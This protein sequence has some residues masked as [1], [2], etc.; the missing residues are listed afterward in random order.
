VV[1]VGG[2]RCDLAT[3]I[4]APD[5]RHAGD[6]DQQVS[7]IPFERNLEVRELDR[8]TR[9][10]RGNHDFSEIG[11]QVGRQHHHERHAFPHG[12]DRVLV[13]IELPHSPFPKMI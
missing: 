11:E 3:K 13:Q 4:R 6:T 8:P 10:H 1:F 5:R 2:E 12:S 9:E 7:I